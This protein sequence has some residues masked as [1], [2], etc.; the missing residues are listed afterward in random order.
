MKKE[1]SDYKV[2]FYTITIIKYYNR[3]FF[4]LLYSKRNEIILFALLSKKSV[5]ILSQ[6][7]ITLPKKLGN[8][9]VLKDNRNRYRALQLMC[10]WLASNCWGHSTSCF[11]NSFALRL[12]EK[13]TL[14][15]SDFASNLRTMEAVVQRCS[16][17]K[18]LLE[19]SQNSQEDTWG[20]VSCLIRLQAWA[21]QLY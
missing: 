19:I 12:I 9:K 1:S 17:R 18:V 3:Y 2:L 16:V 15:S 10:T 21:L 11:I 20:R 14:C 8:L 7:N 6:D 4:S 5:R 13:K